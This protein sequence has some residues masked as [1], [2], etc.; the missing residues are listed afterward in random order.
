M[1]VDHVDMP[2]SSQQNW[3]RLRDAGQGCCVRH[4]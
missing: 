2:V 1:G 4:R 3:Q